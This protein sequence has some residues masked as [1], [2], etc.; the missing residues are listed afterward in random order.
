MTRVKHQR[1]SNSKK[2]QTTEVQHRALYVFY[3][4]IYNEFITV[5]E[6]RC[7]KSVVGVH[8]QNGGNVYQPGHQPR[9][10]RVIKIFVL[11]KALVRRSNLRTAKNLITAQLRECH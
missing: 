10:I 7:E 2:K 1:H 5:I 3:N 6:M 9:M 8:R 11:I 4:H